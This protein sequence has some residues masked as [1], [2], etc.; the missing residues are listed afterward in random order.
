[1]FRWILVVMV[2]LS[3]CGF[4]T[5]GELD[6]FEKASKKK[7][8]SSSYGSG[9]WSDDDD[10]D[11]G[12]LGDMVGGMLEV[13]LSPFGEFCGMVFNG[14]VVEGGA[15]SQDL[16]DMDDPEGFD[17]GMTAAGTGGAMLPF[18]RADF[19]YRDVEGDI[20][21]LEYRLEAGYGAFALGFDHSHYRE[22]EPDD[23]LDLMRIQA[24]LRMSFSDSIEVGTGFGALVIDGDERD[25][26]FSFSLPTRIG[27]TEWIGVELRP[28]WSESV[29]D[30]EASLLVSGDYASLKAGYRWVD[31]HEESLGGPFIGMAIHY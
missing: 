30:F 6:D 27:I 1:M 11:D 16:A 20:D 7:D 14:V 31:S 21:A 10:D 3:A 8:R 13:I 24:I 26:R 15:L 4:V 18:L 28:A 25:T 2:C 19:G 5:A 9:S 17:G 29:S 23:E 12:I 22:D